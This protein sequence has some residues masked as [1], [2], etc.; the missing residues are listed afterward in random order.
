MQTVDFLLLSLSLYNRRASPFV[1]LRQFEM[2]PVHGLQIRTR[3]EV[4]TDK[5]PS[6]SALPDEVHALLGGIR[7]NAPFNRMLIITNRRL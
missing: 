7:R 2:H 5:T 1:R 3:R 6:I 4:N